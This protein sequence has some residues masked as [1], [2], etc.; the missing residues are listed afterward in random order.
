MKNPPPK[1]TLYEKFLESP[2]ARKLELLDPLH[3]PICEEL[4]DD[5]FKLKEHSYKWH[6]WK[7]TVEDR[8]F[9]GCGGCDAYF[10]C[11]LTLIKHTEKSRTTCTV[12]F[13]FRASSQRDPP[14]T[15]HMDC[16]QAA[17]KEQQ[18]AAEQADDTP[19]TSTE[20]VAMLERA[21]AAYV[22]PASK[23]KSL[24]K[25]SNKASKKIAKKKVK[26]PHVP[27]MS[28]LKKSAAARRKTRK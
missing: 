26:K 5:A 19:S 20:A 13:V 18:A 8:S 15:K 10:T 28:I 25:V 2:T 27:G 3:C 12:K 9:F 7:Y 22:P 11:P 16:N 24:E 1:K 17:L 21:A 14:A 4:V 6:M 23:R